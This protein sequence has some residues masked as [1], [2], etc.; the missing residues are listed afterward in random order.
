MAEAFK[1]FSEQVL[2]RPLA[3]PP[4]HPCTPC[5]SLTRQFPNNGQTCTLLSRPSS[6]ALSSAWS[7]L[8]L[9]LILRGSDLTPL[10]CVAYS[11]GFVE[12]TLPTT[13]RSQL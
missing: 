13:R 7:S 12:L 4:F 3:L 9:P 6:L 1:G 11:E 10:L 5:S 8:S 2:A